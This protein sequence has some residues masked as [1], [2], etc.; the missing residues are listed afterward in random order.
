MAQVDQTNQE[1]RNLDA[2]VKERQE[3]LEGLYDARNMLE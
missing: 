3:A 1:L 2:N